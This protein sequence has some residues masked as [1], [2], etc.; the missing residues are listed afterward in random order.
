MYYQLR[1]ERMRGSRFRGKDQEF[2]LGHVDLKIF[3]S[4]PSS[5]VK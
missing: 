4:H 5:D 1:Q 3:I 2:L